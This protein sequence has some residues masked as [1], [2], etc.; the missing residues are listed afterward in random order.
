MTTLVR[1]M[2]T[3]DLPGCA[4]IACAPVLKEVYGFTEK[5]W[6]QRLSKVLGEKDNL[7]FVAEHG[8]ELAGFAWGHERGAFLA[9]PYLRFIAVGEG[10]KGLGIGKLLLAEFEK[11]TSHVGKDFFLL[12]SDFNTSA[13]C[14][15]SQ[16]GYTQAGALPGFAV[17][18][19]S[20]II[21]VKKRAGQ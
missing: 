1:P 5:S 17:P 2:L 11:R 21:M 8:Q 15:Y 14:F 4:C 6:V 20:E 13:I 16:Q 12:V 18:G 7:L 10:F 9:A 3:G 19:V